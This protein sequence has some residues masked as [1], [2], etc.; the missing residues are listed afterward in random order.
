MMPVTFASSSPA[1]GAMKL[2]AATDWYK[3]STCLARYRYSVVLRRKNGLH[4]S[5]Q[6]ASNRE[7]GLFPHR[8]QVWN[9]TKYICN[10]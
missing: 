9:I 1:K 7:A 3:V 6:K 5:P 2:T 10:N 4:L 8:P